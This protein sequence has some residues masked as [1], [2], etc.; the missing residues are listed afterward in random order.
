M[1]PFDEALDKNIWSLSDKRLKLDLEVAMKR[2]SKPKEIEDSLRDLYQRQ[3][4]AETGKTVSVDETQ[5]IESDDD[6][7]DDIYFVLLDSS[8]CW[9]C[10]ALRDAYGDIQEVVAIVSASS[11]ELSQVS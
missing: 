2:R 4:A 11:E 9:F 5:D 8:T 1:E 6:R 7:K 10:S 3:Q